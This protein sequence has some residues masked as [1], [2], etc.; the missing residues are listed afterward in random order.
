MIELEILLI[1]ILSFV[2]VGIFME[3]FILN[4]LAR[5][6]KEMRYILEDTLNG[7]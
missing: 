2:G 1:V 5:D 6:L 3:A 4:E 7:N